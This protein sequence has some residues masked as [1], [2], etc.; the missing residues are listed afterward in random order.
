MQNYTRAVYEHDGLLPIPEDAETTQ[1]GNEYYPEGLAAVVRF[2][3]ENLKMPMMITENGVGTDDDIRRVA[4]IN[5]AL[6]GGH[7]CITEGYEILGCMHW[8][9][10]DNFE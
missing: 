9:L 4:F 6:K 3:S 2:V 5:R 8:C 1:M 7:D 10:K